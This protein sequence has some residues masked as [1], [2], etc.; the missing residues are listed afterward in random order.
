MATHTNLDTNSALEAH[1]NN[2]RS[3][4]PSFCRTAC[5]PDST[6]TLLR[7]TILAMGVLN[8]FLLLGSL[9]TVGVRFVGYSMLL[10]SLASCAQISFI[11][12]VLGIHI[13]ETVGSLGSLGAQ[14]AHVLRNTS[15]RYKDDVYV[16]GT[17]L[18]ST[19][20]MTILMQFVSSYYKGVSACVASLSAPQ[21]SVHNFTRDASIEEQKIN[22]PYAS[23]GASGP[24]GLVAFF[25]GSLFWVN[26]GFAV[27]LYVKRG[28]I[29]SGV[30]PISSS[31]HD[32][33]EIGVE[34]DFSG[35]FPS[36]A[37]TMH[38]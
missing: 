38:V 30:A 20:I 25:S 15:T 22:D 31:Q 37:A 28:E 18:G 13:A 6:S 4:T 34:N 27:V 16:H 7:N 3:K 5:F 23:C 29:I 2:I 33:D 19:L 1:I 9:S 32:Y 26:A 36:A 10:L 17:L 12:M 11:G 14:L 21:E 24:V 8:I 35:D